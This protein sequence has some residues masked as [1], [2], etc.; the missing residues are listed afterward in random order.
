MA[1]KGEARGLPAP[2]A[3]DRA[4]LG[5]RLQPLQTHTFASYGSAGSLL[6]VRRAR[7]SVRD[8]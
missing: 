5:F 6:D 7:S 2:G 8:R 3:L 1:T 4:L